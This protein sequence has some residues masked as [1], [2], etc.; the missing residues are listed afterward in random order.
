MRVQ[1]ESWRAQVADKDEE[2]ARLAE[3]LNRKVEEARATMT[4]SAAGMMSSS[5]ESGE[6]D[7]LVKKLQ[8]TVAEQK[9]MIEDFKERLHMKGDFNPDT[10]KVL[11]MA[12]NPIDMAHQ[13]YK[14][15]VETL[16]KENEQMRLR[17]EEFEAQR[18]SSTQHD[19]DV[20]ERV[21]LRLDELQ[22]ERQ[23]NE[24]KEKIVK[25]EKEK[26]RAREI[27]SQLAHKY[28]E[29]CTQLTGFQCKMKDENLYQVESVY[30]PGHFFLFKRSDEGDLQ[31]LESDYTPQ[32]ADFVETYL[33]T[34]H[35]IPA[36]LAA[37]T[38][39]LYARDGK[40]DMQHDDTTA[41]SQA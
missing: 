22:H 30:E 14:H 16:K 26:Q 3:Q 18:G 23:L 7:A 13:E 17:L 39:Q 11:H 24:L 25:L 33:M 29:M 4:S 2:I 32:W 28:R 6:S 37:V 9:Q 31:L 40:S 19:A 27:Q 5:G 1:C 36:F 20:T 12:I 21:Q 34:D 38:M 8:A 41:S 15:E 35:C 10:T